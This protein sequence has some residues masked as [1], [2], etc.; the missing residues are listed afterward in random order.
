MTGELGFLP[1]ELS[2]VV[3]KVNLF[4]GLLPV[5]IGVTLARHPK[6]EKRKMMYLIR[7]AN[8][9]PFPIVSK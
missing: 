4:P 3:S 1:A 5:E 8:G 9:V 7:L 2:C 6:R